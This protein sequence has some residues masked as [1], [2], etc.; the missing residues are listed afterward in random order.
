MTPFRRSASAI[1]AALSFCITASGQCTNSSPFPSQAITPDPTGQVTSITGC[2]WQSEYATITGIVAG[3]SYEF[4]YEG[5]AWVTVHQ[6]TYNGTVLGFGHSP[7]TVDAVTAGNLYVHWNVDS[8]CVTAQNC[9]AT[10]VQRLGQGCTPPEATVGLLPDCENNEFSIGVVVVNTGDASSVGLSWTVNGGTPNTLTGLP[11]GTYNL[12]PFENGSVIDVTVVHAE[13]PACS[14]VVNDLT[15]EPCATQSCGPDTYTFC[16]GNNENYVQTY[17]GTSSYPLQLHFN[18]GNV[19]GSG[20]DALVIHDGLLPTDPVL[21]SGVGNAGNLTG[22]TVVSTNP[23]HALTLTFTSNS[24]FS[25]ADGGVSPPWN[26]TVGCLDCEPASG[27]A[28]LVTTDCDA[29]QFSVSVTVSSMGSADTVEIANNAGLAATAVTEP[30]VYEAGPFPVGVPVQ[31]SLVNA[32]SAICTLPLGTFENEFCPIMISCAGPALPQ[33]YCYT[34]SDVH[35]WLYQ[36]SGTESLAILFSSGSIESAT[37][38]HLRIYDGYDNG[39]P[40]LYDHIILGTE[41]LANLL[42]ISTGTSLY[43]EMSSD[44]SVSCASGSQSQWNWTVGCLDCEQPEASFSVVLDCDN[45]QFSIATEVSVLGSDPTVTI[46]NT[47][48]APV[49]EVEAV[50][51][52][53]VGPFPLGA[54][55]Q[56]YLVVDNVL[57]GIH[58]PV[59]TNAPCPLIGCGPYQFTYCYPNGMD[60]T[61]VYQS[62][63]TY[64]IALLFNSG[65]IDTFGDLIEVYDGLDFQAPLIYSG[66][67]G[68][69][70][71]GLQFTSTN[72][73]NALCLRFFSNGFTSCASNGGT[74]WDW[75]VSCLDCTNPEATFELVEDCIHHGYTVAVNV[76]SLGTASDLRITDSWSQDTLSGVGL[77]TTIVGPIP[78]GET[79]HI[80]V[81]NGSNP[82]CRINSEAFTLAPAECVVTACETLGAAY[83]YGDDDTAW[84]VYQSGETTPVTVSFA[85][86]QLLDGDEIRIYNGLDETA[87]LVFAGNLGGDMTGLAISSSNPDN[88]LM[89]QIVSDS[90]G[91]CATGE[92]DP[93]LYWTVGCGLV[94]L[95]EQVLDHT[96]LFPQPCDGSLNVSWPGAEEEQVRL[97]LFDV[98]GRCVLDESYAASPGGLRTLDTSRLPVGGYAMRLSSRRNVFS[99]QVLIQR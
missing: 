22:V 82:L 94:G 78:V 46:T 29:Q 75:S 42:V 65:T 41:Q 61:I 16:Y 28:G 95:D 66:S 30:G 63:S 47:G 15:N 76:S 33:T 36:N 96:L 35:S 57:C 80:T 71:T 67:N 14:L 64:P 31:L 51:T 56:V 74:P 24:S 43:M 50:G 85:Y 88:A 34:D 72:P 2:N 18:S 1:A 3:A 86:G 77:G 89:F 11:P 49:I 4:T 58:S 97:R 6:G 70:L 92:A 39:A 84:F 7:L 9:H 26:Y 13:E 53:N 52:Y 91:S 62:A 10:T 21:F 68:G 12:G 19:S 23:D 32:E 98:T 5:G 60:T 59:L 93:Q 69:D 27:E 83:C 20:N 54:D 17:Q 48:G 44:N 45:S 8:L 99:G 40:L 87:Q 55:V 37:Y 90:L 38:D 73:D 25:C 81:L 79:A